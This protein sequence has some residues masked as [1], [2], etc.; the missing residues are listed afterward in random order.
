MQADKAATQVQKAAPKVPAKP[1]QKVS[2]LLPGDY[3]CEAG[4]Y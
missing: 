3:I 2:G 1:V 4:T